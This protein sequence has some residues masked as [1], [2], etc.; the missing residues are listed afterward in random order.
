MFCLHK[1]NL[2]QRLLFLQTLQLLIK[3][4]YVES[5]F[6]LVQKSMEVFEVNKTF[7]PNGAT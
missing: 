6:H 2:Y 1:Q 4:R 7:N 5:Y 3:N